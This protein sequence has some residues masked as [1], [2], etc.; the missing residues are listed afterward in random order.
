MVETIER[1]KTYKIS[2][3][4]DNRFVTSEDIASRLR[5]Q[6]LTMCSFGND[7]GIDYAGCDPTA[8]QDTCGI[9]YA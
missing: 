4:N 3:V 5:E 6:S 8:I 9:D 1:P 7:C 2:T